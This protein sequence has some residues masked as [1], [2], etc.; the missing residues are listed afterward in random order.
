[1]L[2]RAGISRLGTGPSPIG[3]ENHGDET[4]IRCSCSSQILRA[5]EALARAESLAGNAD[6]AAVHL[7]KAKAYAA[8]VQE[9]NDRELLLKDLATL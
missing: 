3:G 8:E 5:Y 6:E 4:R 9:K 1:V 2:T 7:E